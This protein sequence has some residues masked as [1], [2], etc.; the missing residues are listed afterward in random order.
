MDMRISKCSFTS[1]QQYTYKSR[2]FENTNPKPIDTITMSSHTSNWETV[3]QSIQE[4]CKDLNAQAK[5]LTA[6]AKDLTAHAERLTAQVG[7]LETMA[8][9][10]KN[11]QDEAQTA[12]LQESPIDCMNQLTTLLNQRMDRMDQGLAEIHTKMLAT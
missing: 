2:A 7:E 12:E 3:E 11:C 6:R 5:D 10:I 1:R 8:A 9:Q 4:A